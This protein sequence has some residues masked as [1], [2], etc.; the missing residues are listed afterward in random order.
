MIEAAP[1]QSELAPQLQQND[2]CPHCVK[3]IARFD[4]FCPH[5]GGPV[6]AH[7]AIDPLS[8]VYAQGYAYRQATTINQ[9]KFIVVLGIWLIFGPQALLL[10]QC[11]QHRS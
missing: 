1:T 9:P 11:D 4:H 10:T 7:A 8:Q 5:C 2:L 3:P 6:T